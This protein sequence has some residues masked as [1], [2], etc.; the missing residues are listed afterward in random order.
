MIR[1]SLL[2]RLLHW[3]IAIIVVVTLGAG[4]IFGI[5]EFDGTKEKFGGPVTDMLYKYH[6]TFGL[7]ILGLMLIRLFVRLEDGK[8][9][10]DYDVAAWEVV[11]SSVVQYLLYLALLVQPIL[12]WMATDASNYPVEFFFWNVPDMIPKSKPMGDLGAT[13]YGLHGIVGWSIVV[14]LVLHIG[15]ALRHW[16]FKRDSVM[17]RM[18]FF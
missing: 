13:L 3:L 9:P 1:F 2:Q 17:R 12:G 14:L 6:K 18:G 4:L 15:G 5:L 10:H 11:A 7:I 8:P 16:I